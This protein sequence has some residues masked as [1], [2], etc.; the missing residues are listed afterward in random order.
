MLTN[1]EKEDIWGKELYYRINQNGLSLK[2]VVTPEDIMDVH[3]IRNEVFVKEQN[4][5]VDDEF[6]MSTEKEAI[7]FLICLYDKPIGTIRY[8]LTDKGVKLER[9]AILKEYRRGGHGK[10][11]FMH[12]VNMLKAKYVPC[13]I[14]FTAQKY[15]IPFYESLGFIKE[16]EIF[17]EAGIEHQY[18]KKTFN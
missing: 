4:V 15:L 18:M 2:P 5:S 12:L 9:F 8:R 6:D 1:F 3:Y 10:Q 17:L 16:G 11:A 13:T 7:H 14:Y